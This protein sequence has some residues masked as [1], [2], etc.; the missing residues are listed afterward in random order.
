[1]FNQAQVLIRQES[2]SEAKDILNELVAKYGHTREATEANQLLMSLKVA[3]E[4]W[5]RVAETWR[6]ALLT[7]LTTFRLDCRR[8]PT[9]EEG[10]KAL[11]VNPGFQ[12]WR[13]PYWR[14]ESA[15]ILDK[16]EYKHRGDYEEPEVSP[17]MAKR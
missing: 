14:L 16:F 10:L 5:E 7:A 11:L 13:G 12:G 15:H 2:L 8:Y 17:R 3:D 9:P 6:Q 4:E 1:M